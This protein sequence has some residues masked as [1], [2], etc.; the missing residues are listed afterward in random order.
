MRGIDFLP[1]LRDWGARRRL[2]RVWENALTPLP[3]LRGQGAGVGAKLTKLVGITGNTTQKTAKSEARQTLNRAYVRAVEAA[4][5]VPLIL[6]VTA[7]PDTIHR[8]LDA[9]DGILLSGGVDVEPARYGQEPHPALGET[10][11]DRD[12]AEI[13]L[14]RAA[15]ERDKPIFAICRGLQILNVAL[16]GSLYQDLPDEKPSE[17]FHAQ[18]ERGVPR[19]ETVHSIR[20]EAG[21][22]LAQ[23]V[24]AE[25]MAVNSLHHQALK[26]VASGLKVT[27]WADDGVIEAAEMPEKRFVVAIQCHPEELARWQTE[28]QQLFAAFVAQ[29][30]P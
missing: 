11:A 13:A 2:D 1:R 20:I 9:L 5:G 22:R 18:N 24:G 4:G 27:A 26:D 14:I 15:L 3:R 10:D 30:G 16:G 23:I 19:P 29:T 7:N 8:C 12:A 28:S 17:I 25:T 21:S 6:P